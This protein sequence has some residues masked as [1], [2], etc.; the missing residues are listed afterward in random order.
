[1][2]EFLPVLPAYREATPAENAAHR[3]HLQRCVVTATARARRLGNAP[4]TVNALNF[5]RGRLEQFDAVLAELA[6]LYGRS[7]TE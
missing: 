4:W 2:P 5:A 6:E 7:P 1:M 3:R